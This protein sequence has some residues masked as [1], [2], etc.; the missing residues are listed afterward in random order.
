MTTL[1]PS[2]PSRRGT[3]GAAA[4]AGALLGAL[5]AAPAAA[6][7]TTITPAA[8]QPG[9]GVLISRSLARWV[10][11][12]V[13]PGRDGFEDVSELRFDLSLA[14]GLSGDTSLL[15][16]LPIVHRDVDGL[17]AG[18]GSSDP[19]GIGD[20]SIEIRHRFVNEPLGP[21]DTLRVAWFAGAQ[22]PGG[23]GTF[24]SDSVDPYAGLALTFITGRLGLGAG[25]SYTA[26]TGSVDRPLHPGDS[27]ADLVRLTGSAAWRLAPESWGTEL[28][29]AWYATL[30]VEAMLETSGE[31]LVR[32]APGLLLEAPTYAIEV[33]A[34][35]PIAEEAQ[36]RPEHDVGVIAGVRLFF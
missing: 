27:T 13:D 14:Y 2:V 4:V 3:A 28:E 7:Q 30:E 26:T 22:I 15:A 34:L 12:D 21:V 25:L 1:I 31:H 11:W 6:Q 24:S 36:R 35:L 10:D 33:A 23:R 32:L 8:T 9:E 17:P 16:T 5:A 19:T 18:G 20:P 29:P